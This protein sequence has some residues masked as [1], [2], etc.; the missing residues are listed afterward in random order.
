S[1]IGASSGPRTWSRLGS[2]GRSRR[3]G[4]AALVD[5]SGRSTSGGQKRNEPAPCPD[6][7]S[8]G[9]TYRARDGRDARTRRRRRAP[10]RAA[11][12]PPPPCNRALARGVSAAGS[13]DGPAAAER[14]Q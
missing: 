14:R 10:R 7:R 4:A 13:P 8:L 3:L 11:A 1:V 5:M 9:G 2:T 6:A 12:P